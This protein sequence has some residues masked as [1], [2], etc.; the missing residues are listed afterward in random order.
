MRGSDNHPNKCLLSQYYS[1]QQ[2]RQ[3]FTLHLLSMQWN[4]INAAPF[5]KRRRLTH[6]TIATTR[7]IIIIRCTAPSWLA[8]RHVAY[9]TATVLGFLRC[10]FRR[11]SK[12]VTVTLV[13]V[14]R[15][16]Q[17]FLRIAYII[18]ARLATVQPSLTLGARIIGPVLLPDAQCRLGPSD[19]TARTK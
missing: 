14:G 6:V 9:L 17:P 15:Y 7:A 16:S 3:L 18:N 1:R 11:W 13:H 2:V 12:T 19:G 5:Q 4:S 8:Y 10:H